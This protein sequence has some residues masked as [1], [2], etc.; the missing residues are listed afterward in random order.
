M[1]FE[2]LV[3]AL[4]AIALIAMAVAVLVLPHAPD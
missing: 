3:Y 1:N 4:V 2:R